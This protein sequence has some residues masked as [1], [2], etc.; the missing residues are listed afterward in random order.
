MKIIMIMVQQQIV[1][2]ADITVNLAKNTLYVKLVLK[3]LIEILKM[4]LVPVLKV[5]LKF[6]IIQFAKNAI[7]NV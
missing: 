5:F 7:P 1:Q 4:E 3:I 6:Q 2:N